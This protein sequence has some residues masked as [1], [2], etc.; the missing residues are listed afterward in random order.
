M[1]MQRAIAKINPRATY[2]LNHSQA[3]E[4]QAILEWRGPG[5][6]PSNTMLEDA[7]KLCLEDDAAL[8]AIEHER[9]AAIER[10]KSNPGLVDVALVLRL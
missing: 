4:L 2:L 5:L 9:D 3:D 10:V 1:D 7:W 6:Q 8:A